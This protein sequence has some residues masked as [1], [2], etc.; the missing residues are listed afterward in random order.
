MNIDVLGESIY[1]ICRKPGPIYFIDFFRLKVFL[2]LIIPNPEP[3]IN[4]FFQP[5][6]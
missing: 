4:L 1:P 5:L 3:L 2:V 6:F